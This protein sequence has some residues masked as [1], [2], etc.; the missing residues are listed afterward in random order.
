VLLGIIAD[1]AD[2]ARFEPERADPAPRLCK[3]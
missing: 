3:K 1:G 2:R